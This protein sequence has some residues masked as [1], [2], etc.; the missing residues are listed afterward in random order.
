MFADPTGAHAATF[1]AVFAT[2]YVAHQV[3]DHWVQTQRQADCKGQPGWAGRIACAAHVATYTLTALITL[4]TMVLATGLRLDPW[5]VG[6]GLTVSAVSHYV[7]DRRTPLQRIAAA[8]GSARFY[9]L[10]APR[11][12]RDDNPS[13]GTGAY[14]LDQ[15]WH[16]GWLFVAALFCA[17]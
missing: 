1:A 13:L 11:P 2:L 16:I 3:A 12:G 4:A 10:G 5:G 6:V 15:S 9:A 17:A 14:A 7:A 8:L